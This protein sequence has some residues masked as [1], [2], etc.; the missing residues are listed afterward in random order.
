MA[1]FRTPHKE[2]LMTR[3]LLKQGENECGLGHVRARALPRQEEELRPHFEP[4]GH[5]AKGAQEV[6]QERRT[7]DPS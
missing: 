4:S 6:A 7:I 1:L 3:F 5:G 2:G